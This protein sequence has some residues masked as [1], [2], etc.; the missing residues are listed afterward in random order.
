MKFTSVCI[1]AVAAS[2][3][4]SSVFSPQEWG[5]IESD[6]ENSL[7]QKQHVKPVQN[8][9]ADDIEPM[10]MAKKPV[11]KQ[12][13]FDD[14]LDVKPVQN[15]FA[16]DM[17]PKASQK[18]QPMKISDLFANDL[19]LKMG[20]P[21][22][23]ESN[24]MSSMEKVMRKME[25]KIESLEKEIK[26]DEKKQEDSMG[27]NLEALKY[28]QKEVSENSKAKAAHLDVIAV[29]ENSKAKAAHLDVIAVTENHATQTAI[30]EEFERVLEQIKIGPNKAQKLAQACQKY[31]SKAKE[32]K[33][34][35]IIAEM[36]VTCDLLEKKYTQQQQQQEEVPDLFEIFN[37]VLIEQ[38]GGHEIK[39]EAMAEKFEE[40]LKTFETQAAEKGETEELQ[41]MK[42]IGSDLLGAFGKKL[43]ENGAVDCG[44][45]KKLLEE[46][47]AQ[48]FHNSTEEVAK[49]KAKFEKIARD[50]MHETKCL[51]EKQEEM[52]LIES[53]MP[54]SV[55]S[56]EIV[57]AQTTAQSSSSSSSSSSSI[58]PAAIAGAAAGAV[59]LV[60]LA[61]GG[62][63]YFVNKRRK[64][65]QVK[66]I[67]DMEEVLKL[68]EL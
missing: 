16:D 28:L 64:R 34:V 9:F 50:I 15:L 40:I 37:K 43:A 48:V 21:V 59:G 19:H 22:A 51:K 33:Q 53:A 60:G 62:G 17:E 29:T 52:Q 38:L 36:N 25:E 63:A 32:A 7:H 18:Q 6:F 10:I 67:H 14:D 11:Q 31:I 41:R 68:T 49:H 4:A 58:P 35:E 47:F 61:V 44:T 39:S 55:Q 8:L 2:A 42:Q 54:L 66:R 23:A 3:S 13:L 65:K 5:N 45:H 24:E 30:S 1:L 26:D 56:D 27:K 20:T 12:H 57:S 46:V